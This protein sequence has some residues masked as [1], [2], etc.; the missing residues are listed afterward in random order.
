MLYETKREVVRIADFGESRSLRARLMRYL[1]AASFGLTLRCGFGTSVVG[2]HPSQT[3]WARAGTE[4]QSVCCGTA[5]TPHLWSLAQIVSLSQVLW[6]CSVARD[7]TAQS[8]LLQLPLFSSMELQTAPG[9]FEDVF[10]SG[11]VFA[12]LLRGS[13]VFMGSSSMDQLYKIFSVAWLQKR[14]KRAAVGAVWLFSLAG[15]LVLLIE[16]L[17]CAVNC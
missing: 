2:G 5:A 15:M 12:E 17:K 13:P 6:D 14:G 8:T 9:S 1:L 3:T 11:L 7:S 16:E 4:L 10:S